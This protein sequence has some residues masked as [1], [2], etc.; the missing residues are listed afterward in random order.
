MSKLRAL[1]V[2]LWF[3][4]VAPAVI[5]LGFLVVRSRPLEGGRS[6]FDSLDGCAFAMLIFGTLWL[7]FYS[8]EYDAYRSGKVARLAPSDGDSGAVS[9]DV[10]RLN[11]EVAARIKE[12]ADFKAALERKNEEIRGLRS[13]LNRAD[14]KAV[15]EGIAEFLL[16]AEFLAMRIA[17]GKAAPD[18]ALPELMAAVDDLLDAAQ[19]K[20]GLP[21]VGDRLAELPPQSCTIF[22]KIDAPTPDKK[23][24][25]AEVR[26]S[27]V[28]F[29][30]GSQLVI[31]SPSRVS[32]YV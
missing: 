27:W 24:Q 19:L 10:A 16:A 12:V 1:A 28:G 4:T 14:L 20:K 15:N 25:L 32:V 13:T 30:S 29:M 22:S 2:S 3:W 17:A 9:E 21:Q 23:G 26:N 11:A 18:A 8:V 31:I 6:T 5:G 7:I